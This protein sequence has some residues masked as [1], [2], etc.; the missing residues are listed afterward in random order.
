MSSFSFPFGIIIGKN[1]ST[2]GS[3][4][5]ASIMFSPPPHLY[6]IEYVCMHTS[7]S[8]LGCDEHLN[9]TRAASQKFVFDMR[10][11]SIFDACCSTVGWLVCRV[12]FYM[13]RMS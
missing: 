12:D 9:K 10:A 3:L 8:F 4:C 1:P 13:R 5:D 11:F 2:F 7:I 6:R